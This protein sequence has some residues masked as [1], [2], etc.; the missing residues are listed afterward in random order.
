MRPKEVV[1]RPRA[2]ND[3]GRLYDYIAEES[4]DIDIAFAYTWR[5]RTACLSLDKF[6]ERGIPRNDISKGLRILVFERRSI[7]AYFVTGRIEIAAIF[8]GGQ[9]WQ[10]VMAGSLA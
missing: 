5:L 7:V 6:P 1:F 4:G 9:D 2:E 10:T 8:H 3:L